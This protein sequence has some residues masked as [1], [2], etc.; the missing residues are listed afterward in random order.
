MLPT[1][2]L[3]RRILFGVPFAVEQVNLRLTPTPTP[4]LAA[5]STRPSARV[6]LALAALEGP[7]LDRPRKRG[8]ARG[9]LPLA[10]SF[11]SL[12]TIA[13]SGDT[14]PRGC[15]SG[16]GVASSN[17]LARLF[18]ENAGGAVLVTTR[19]SDLFTLWSGCLDANGTAP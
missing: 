13:L 14:R 11:S 16:R 6:G 7:H 17:T 1:R 4:F 2:R 10:A 9:G 19:T 5:A 15:L 18:R 8:R 3:P 12:H